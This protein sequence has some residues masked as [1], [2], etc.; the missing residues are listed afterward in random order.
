MN[1]MYCTLCI[2]VHNYLTFGRTLWPVN[3]FSC[4]SL[5]WKLSFNHRYCSILAYCKLRISL[6]GVHV[7]SILSI[8]RCRFLILFLV[9]SPISAW[10][11]CTHIIPEGLSGCYHE[12]WLSTNR[13]I[14]KGTLAVIR[15]IHFVT[16]YKEVRQL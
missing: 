5:L 2:K 14:A 6:I 7:D 15:F 13:A 11:N 4:C 1:I 10:S 12:P 8:Q 16:P 9:F 3:C